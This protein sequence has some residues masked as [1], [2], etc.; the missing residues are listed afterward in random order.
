[1]ADRLRK[2]TPAVM[3]EKTLES[4]RNHQ[5]TTVNMNTDQLFHGKLADGSDAPDYSQTSILKF[6][7][8]P[9]PWQ[10]YGTGDFF[11]DFYIKAYRFPIVFD[12]RDLKVPLIFEAIEAKGLNPDEIFGLDKANRKDFA[13]SYV[14]PD[15]QREIRQA[16]RVR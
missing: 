12:S 4:V 1:M 8:R 14:L 2:L 6:G 11:R 9:G 16:I 13:R 3:R 15:L 5:E 7:K 10:F